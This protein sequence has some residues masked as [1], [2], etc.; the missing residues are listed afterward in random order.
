MRK[1]ARW[2]LVVFGRRRVE[3]VSYRTSVQINNIQE[4]R[5]FSSIHSDK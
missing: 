2:S 4:L 5:K 1:V 3:F